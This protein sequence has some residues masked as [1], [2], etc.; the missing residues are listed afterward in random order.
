MFVT[1]VHDY[2]R[3]K[4]R[5]KAWFTSR[6]Q[7]T[8]KGSNCLYVSLHVYRSS[9]WKIANL[10]LFGNNHLSHHPY[11]YIAQLTTS[12]LQLMYSIIAIFSR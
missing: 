11:P 4:S 6:V 12:N 2:V 7:V 5:Q 9:G 1:C 8:N 10:V 3:L